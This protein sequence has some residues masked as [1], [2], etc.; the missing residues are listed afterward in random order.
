MEFVAPWLSSE[1]QFRT[2][3]FDDASPGLGIWG[4]GEIRATGWHLQADGILA[5]RR[6][7]PASPCFIGAGVVAF[8][9]ASLKVGIWFVGRPGEFDAKRGPAASPSS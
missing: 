7:G 4:E 5:G 6:A 8:L 1:D 9:R 3:A 2:W